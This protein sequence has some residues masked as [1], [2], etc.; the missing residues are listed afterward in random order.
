MALVV[1]ALF[2]ACTDSGQTAEVP[3]TMASNCGLMAGERT[4][5]KPLVDSIT[6]GWGRC[7]EE[8]QT[9]CAIKPMERVD[10]FLERFQSPTT[11]FDDAAT[12]DDLARQ[13][14]QIGD[15]TALARLESQLPEVAR[16]YADDVGRRGFIDDLMRAL[17][18]LRP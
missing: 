2:G 17:T 13:L 5:G 14:S 9:D 7:L 10:S 16:Q 12:V 1:S 18:R 8:F 3:G 11:N 4:S 6:C 15:E